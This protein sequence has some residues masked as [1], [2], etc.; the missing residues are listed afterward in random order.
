MNRDQSYLKA[1]LQSADIKVDNMLKE[2]NTLMDDI[3]LIPT[4][5]GVDIENILRVYHGYEDL[6]GALK[7]CKTKFESARV[8]E[9]LND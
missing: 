9:N 1:Y 7:A 5:N 3:W 6:Q 2:L 8:K 4:G